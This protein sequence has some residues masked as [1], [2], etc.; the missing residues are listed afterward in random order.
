MFGHEIKI[1]S[2]GHIYLG[3]VAGTQKLKKTFVTKK[4]MNELAILIYF[5]RWQQL[6]HKSLSTVEKAC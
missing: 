2:K 4:Q 1:I 3:G 6:N 5:Q